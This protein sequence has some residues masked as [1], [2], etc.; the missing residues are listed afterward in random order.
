[1][2]KWFVACPPW[3]TCRTVIREHYGVLEDYA[4]K[5]FSEAFPAFNSSLAQ[6]REMNK[7]I[8]SLILGILRS[9][10]EKNLRSRTNME[11]SITALRTL[12]ALKRFIRETGKPP[13]S[14][15]E[16][17]PKF[18]DHLPRDPFDGEVLRY[19]LTPYP[20]STL[21]FRLYA[22]DIDL[23]D[24]GGEFESVKWTRK[25]RDDEGDL[26]LTLPRPAPTPIDY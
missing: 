12:I 6:V 8:P 26:P 5:P 11:A 24:D 2:M 25:A 17:V 7:S 18:L 3:A 16:L 1:M 15:D 22:V 21:P 9:D 13:A 23:E 19:S 4:D 20:G 10:F 14:L